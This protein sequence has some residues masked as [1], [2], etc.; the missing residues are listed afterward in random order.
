MRKKDGWQKHGAWT[1]I[2]ICINL[3]PEDRLEKASK[4]CKQMKNLY[5]TGALKRQKIVQADRKVWTT[6]THDHAAGLKCYLRWK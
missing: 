5:K 3:L 4:W 6:I 2:L 1:L